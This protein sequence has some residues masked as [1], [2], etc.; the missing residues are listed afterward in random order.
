MRKMDA[1]HPN[2]NGKSSMYRSRKT[3]EDR[4]TNVILESFQ[5]P[6]RTWKFHYVKHFYAKYRYQICRSTDKQL[7]K[8]KEVGV[9]AQTT[10]VQ[11]L[12]T[13]HVQQENF[14]DDW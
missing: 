6:Q 8:H 5:A 11:S 13:K 9:K 2:S 7:R 10:I 14:D 12:V 1:S 3:T 4:Q